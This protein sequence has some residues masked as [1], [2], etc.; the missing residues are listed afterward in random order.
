MSIA[1]MS[2]V[3]QHSASGGNDRLVLLAIADHAGDDGTNAYPSVGRLAR[4]AN[5]SERTVQRCIQSLIGLG[6]LEVEFGSGHRASRYT[7]L[8]KEGRQSVTPPAD[9]KVDRGDNLSPQPRQ[10]DTTGASDCHPSGDTAG[11]LTVLEPSVEPSENHPGSAAAPRDAGR[12][13]K[14]PK[15]DPAVVDALCKLLADLIE[16]NGSKRPTVTKAW[17]DACRLMIERDDRD[18]VKITNAIKWCQADEFWR[19]NIL[20]MPKLREKYDQI[21]LAAQRQANGGRPAA[22]STARERLAESRRRQE[23]LA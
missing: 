11:T 23:M 14:A 21:R 10:T 6:E 5:I 8:M 7:V 15:T 12:K 17:Q 22:P 16:Q 18:P 20:S 3:W 9:E 13:P 19:A 1:V 2:W 4:K